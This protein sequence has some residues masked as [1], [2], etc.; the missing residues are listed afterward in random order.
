LYS[1][2]LVLFHAV[3][4]RAP[5]LRARGSAALLHPAVGWWVVVVGGGGCG[6][7]QKKKKKK[8]EPPWGK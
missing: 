6:E 2:H 4:S 1:P 7:F 3:Y 8:K 5:H